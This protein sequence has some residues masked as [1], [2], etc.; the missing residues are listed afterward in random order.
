MNHVI[1]ILIMVGLYFFFVLTPAK[2][3]WLALY[4]TIILG[5]S[6]VLFFQWWMTWQGK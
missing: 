6:G 1:A 2:W 4:A 5:F 3:V